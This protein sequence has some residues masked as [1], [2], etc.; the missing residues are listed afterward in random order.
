MLD[1]FAKVYNKKITEENQPLFRITIAEQDIMLPP[2]FC[3]FDNV[4]ASVKKSK[5]MRDALGLTHVVPREKMRRIQSLVD[6]LV[7]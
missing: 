2:E 6:A 7:K 1:Y 4:S 3:L 5:E